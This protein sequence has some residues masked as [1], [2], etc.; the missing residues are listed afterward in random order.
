MDERDTKIHA[1]EAELAALKKTTFVTEKLPNESWI[2]SV[3]RRLSPQKSKR[4]LL[5]MLKKIGRE[6]E[7]KIPEEVKKVIFGIRLTKWPESTKA[8][9]KFNS[10]NEQCEMPFGHNEPGV[11]GERTN[12]RRVHICAI[13]EDVLGVGVFHRAQHC[14]LLKYLDDFEK[15]DSFDRPES[16][17]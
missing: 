10:I 4:D 11:R 8:C 2:E 6:I 7:P 17:C 13:C 14:G 9:L 16:I 3:E 5:E 12:F 15:M 1:L